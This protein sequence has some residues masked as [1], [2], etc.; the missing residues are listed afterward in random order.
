MLRIAHLSDFH[1]AANH[2]SDFQEFTL[3]AL[4]KD[5]LEF[6]KE[7]KIDLILFSGDLI[8][9]G[10][11]SFNKDIE[12]AFMSFNE[13]VI[14]PIQKALSIDKDKFLFVPGNHDIDQ[15]AIDEIYEDGLRHRLNSVESVN[16]FIERNS[17]SGLER[18]LAFKNF[19]R[20]HF[21]G[22]SHQIT[23]FSSN[24][25][26]EINNLQIGVACLNS[27]WR[28]CDN[29]DKERLLIG[30]RQLIN[31]R[32]ELGECDIKI[33]VV[34]HP[35]DWLATFDK[36]SVEQIITKDY[37][38]LFC[39]HVHEGDTVTKTSMLGSLFISTTP[40]NWTSNLRS[41]DR[42]YSNGYNIIDYANSEIISYNRRYNH[43]QERFDP[44]TDLG[45]KEGKAIFLIPNN[46][47]LERRNFE[48][49]TCETIKQVH[50]GSRDE[51]LLSFKT[52]TL[53][54]KNIEELFVLPH[55]VGNEQYDADNQDKEQIYD[56]ERLC[57]LSGHSIFI[58]NK[59]SGKTILLDRLMIEF[60]N[61]I[62]KYRKIPVYIDLED[63]RTSK[64][65]TD[66]SRFLNVGIHDIDSLL[67]NYQIVLLIDNLTPSYNRSFKIKEI[68]QITQ[69]YSNVQVFATCISLLDGELPIELLEFEILPKFRALK[70][71]PF[72]TKQIKALTQKWFSKNQNYQKKELLDDLIKIF[73]KLNI[74]RTPL[75]VSMFL[76]IIEYQ[77]SYKPVNNATML[78]N[79]VE[80]LF[81]KHSSKEIYS[82]EFDFTNKQR[83]L[84]DIALHM[85]NNDLENY[86]IPSNV[87]YNHIYEYLK[88]RK[89]LFRVDDVLKEFIEVGVLT[90]EHGES[91]LFVRFR[92]SCFFKYFLMKNMDYRVEFKD[93][94]L[95]ED[96]YLKFEDEIEY[97]T[98][99]KRDQAGVL[100]VI[101]ERMNKKF[102]QLVEYF[103]SIPSG[104]DVAFQTNESIINQ[105]DNNY[106]KRLTNSDKP[107]EEE[108]DQIS[109]QALENQ[110]DELGIEK[111]YDLSKPQELER[112]WTLAAKVL[113]NTEETED[114]ALKSKSFNDLL[115]CSSAFAT[116]Y[117]IFLN[118]HFEKEDG[119]NDDDLDVMYK[120][121]PLAHQV[122][123]YSLVGTAK[124][125]VVMKED[126]QNKLIDNPND[127]TE[128]EKYLS[129]FI[130]S[131]LKG[132]EY[133]KYIA[134]LIK[135]T[136]QSYINDM[137]LFKLVTYY[138]FRSKN[139]SMDLQYLNLIGDLII[140]VRND[141]KIKKSKIF[142]DYRLKRAK[143]LR[144]SNSEDEA[145]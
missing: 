114:G 78:E 55:I 145:I 144:S 76:W 89:F 87:L 98:G 107:T 45:D 68:E 60:S 5:L 112:S 36:R 64:I 13:Y 93:F 16:N 123:T 127:Y 106:L 40:S 99:L 66:I 21:S 105:L 18:I 52:D 7:K 27:S 3:K 96:N 73:G 104:F 137:I 61:N 31:A 46:G 54:P 83:L 38:M 43:A 80:R 128:F 111:K 133:F 51:H 67:T 12:L 118:K 50:Y 10:G 62:D 15:S 79:F 84:A 53:A 20:D 92:F 140:K 86:K 14:E 124:L 39:G 26:F 6:H 109:D 119:K 115:T 94:V 132:P 91:E 28:C 139:Q 82:E 131:D 110:K 117:K 4:I 103:K 48:K 49:K 88:A 57:E 1:L 30:E 8:D 72:K 90:E 95:H 35:L 134:Q 108:L 116:L 121:L 125:S 122:I 34:H 22:Y 63:S 58:G 130:Y 135:D 102:E 75:A 85:Y 65:F 71:A 138:Y 77:E 29:N 9:K 141:P 70:I 136:K 74:P 142:E 47:E 120:V 69:K 129:V 56:L 44:N 143:K 59:E 25:K 101:V 23:N 42:N 24:F 97:F 126:I 41:T 32:K 81:R 33:A 2:I 11:M 17:T 113:K 37:D 19:E 100:Q